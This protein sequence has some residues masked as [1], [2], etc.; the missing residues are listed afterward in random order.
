VESDLDVDIALNL[1]GG[2]SSGLWMPNI[3]TIDSMTSVPAVIAVM[4]R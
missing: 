1:D 4:S 2:P 3:A